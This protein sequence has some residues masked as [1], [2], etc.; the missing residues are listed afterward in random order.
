[1]LDRRRGQHPF[2]AGRVPLG[3]VAERTELGQRSGDERADRP[4]FPLDGDD[5]VRHPNLPQPVG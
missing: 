2:G 4:T 3:T 5:L 1:M